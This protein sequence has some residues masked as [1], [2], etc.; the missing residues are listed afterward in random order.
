MHKILIAFLL[1]AFCLLAGDVSGKWSG[2]MKPNGE[3][4]AGPAFLVLKQE[5]AEL[6]GSAG[7]NESQQHPIESGKVEGDRIRFE[8]KVGEKGTISFDL[9]LDGDQISGD[10]KMVRDAE[11]R[12]ATLSVQRV[13]S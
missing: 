9:K 5:G 3:E 2:T 10:L 8:I 4:N 1:S 6:K 13:K 11:S 7:P 12:T